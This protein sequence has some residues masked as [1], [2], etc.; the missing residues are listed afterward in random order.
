LLSLRALVLADLLPLVL[1][2]LVHHL[3]VFPV[4]VV[5]D[6]RLILASQI[7]ILA[8]LNSKVGVLFF[9]NDLYVVLIRSWLWAPLKVVNSGA[10]RGTREDG[11]LV[12]I[13][14]IYSLSV[15]GLV[16]HLKSIDLDVW[17]G[18]FLALVEDKGLLLLSVFLFHLLLGS[19]QEVNIVLLDSEDRYV[20]FVH[21]GSFLK[22]VGEDEKHFKGV[23][24]EDFHSKHS[25]LALEVLLP[26]GNVLVF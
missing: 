1:E 6:P 23:M 8:R 12:S 17:G 4:F 19:V 24:G 11:F 2:V 26:E 13:E 16:C 15:W 9:L 5:L 21:E 22:F 10:R 18:T 20:I 7:L 14:L 3:D 25:H